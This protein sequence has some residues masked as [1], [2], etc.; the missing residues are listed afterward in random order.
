MLFILT[1]DLIDIIQ[2]SELVA[3]SNLLVI[4][5]FRQLVF[6]A[7]TP[8]YKSR[9]ESVRAP[10]RYKTFARAKV[11]LILT[12][13][14]N[15]FFGGDFDSVQFPGRFTKIWARKAKN[16]GRRVS[17]RE[18]QRGVLKLHNEFSDDIPA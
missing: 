4:S 11:L 1:F 9:T 7:Q 16:L 13:G 6:Q 3:C 2:G 15:R 5:K 18:C 8:C 10:G 14:R 12:L 17:G